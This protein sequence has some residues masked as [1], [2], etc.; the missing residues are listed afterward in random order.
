VQSKGQIRV[1][2]GTP[3]ARRR[4]TA[5]AMAVTALATIGLL[6]T[7]GAYRGSV[8]TDGEETIPDLGPSPLEAAL[9]VAEDFAAAWNRGDAA[10][11]DALIADEFDWVTLPGLTD[12]HFGPRDTRAAL[13]DGVRFLTSVTALQLGP[14]DAEVAPPDGRASVLV[15][16]EDAEFR[17]DYLDAVRRNIW[18]ASLPEPIARAGDAP[19]GMVFA[20]DRGAIVGIDLD[21]DR[22]AP[23][24]YCI[25]AEEERPEAAATMFD[26]HC[27]PI[28][29]P[30]NGAAHADAAAAF[31]A[32]GAPLP[33]R[34]LAEARV[35]AAYVDRFVE[36]HNVVDTLTAR[37]W[38]SASVE[39]A[40]LPG[41]PGPAATPPIADY[42]A[43]SGRLIDI[44]TGRCTVEISGE[45]T[46]VTCP[47]M[48]AG[49]RL[50]GERLPQPTRF[51]IDANRRGNPVARA[52]GRILAIEPLSDDPALLDEL[53]RRLRSERPATAD[54]AFDDA[55]T[56]TYTITAADALAAALQRS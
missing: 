9:L 44:E 7:A 37:S 45:R 52:Q 46:I 34:E 53:C 24:A 26:L 13:G 15:R 18:E 48:T 38:L 10:A 54:L 27:R 55:C 11:A 49:G 19:P 22:Y 12:P 35:A 30:A 1:E 14:C 31:V 43:W 39:A 16:C 21:L 51:V 17:G 56:P 2:G 5:P 20:V 8:A 3:P 4:W 28:T 32:A 50:L 40:D 25:W 42:L 36:L 41:F 23:Q 33:T 47:D 6:A 29:S